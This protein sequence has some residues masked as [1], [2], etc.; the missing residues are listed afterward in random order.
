MRR[1][2]ITTITVTGTVDGVS[3]SNT[4]TRYAYKEPSKIESFGMWNSSQEN[5]TYGIYDWPTSWAKNT[6]YMGKVR[7]NPAIMFT[8]GFTASTTGSNTSYDTYTWYIVVDSNDN[9]VLVKQSN[10]MNCNM[11]NSRYKYIQ[12]IT[13]INISEFTSYMGSYMYVT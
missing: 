12:K 8:G 10:W 5:Y 6:T 3:I 13:I 7:Y 11:S 4:Y 9:S 1:S 2:P